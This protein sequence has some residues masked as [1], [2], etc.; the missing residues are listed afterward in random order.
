VVSECIEIDHSFIPKTCKYRPKYTN[1]E[2][3]AISRK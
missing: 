2:L 1:V 3:S